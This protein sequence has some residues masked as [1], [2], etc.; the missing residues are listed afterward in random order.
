MGTGSRKAEIMIVGE[1]PGAREDETHA[2]FVGPAGQLLTSLLEEVGISRDQCY[3]TNAAKCR[4]PGNA[5]P[6]RGEAKVCANTYLSEEVARVAP[7]HI[8]TLGNTALQATTGRSGITK[9]R[10]KVF[11]YGESTLFP[12]FHPAAAL[13]S[14]RYLP[15]I[16]ADFAAFSRLLSGNGGSYGPKTRVKIINT[17]AQLNWLIGQL[18]R[19]PTTAFDLE[20][21]GLEEWK[22]DARIVTL[23]FSWEAGTAAVVPLYHPERHE[24]KGLGPDQVLK[25]LKGVL[26]GHPKLVAHNGKF[27]ARWLASAGIFVE[28]KFDT[29]LAAHLLDENNPKGLK[30]LA[31][32][33]LGADDYDLG[34]ELQ[35]AQSIPLKRLCIYNGKDCDYTFRLRELFKP[36]LIEEGR[37]ARLFTKLIMPASNALTRVER[38]GLWVDSDRLADR[39]AQAEEVLRKL[40]AYMDQS[41][42]GIN[43]N[44]P[45]QV[46]LW[47]FGDLG[48]PILEETGTGNPSTRE[49]VLFALESQSQYVKALLKYR[50][51][52][53]WLTTYLIP[54]GEHTDDR[55]RIHTSY[56]LHG[57]V[58]GRLSSRGPNL[59]QV[60]R[61]PFIRG[62]LGAPRGWVFV[63]ADY[64]QIELRIA[65]M[66]AHERTMLRV[67]N[68]GQDLHTTTAVSI[69]RK[70]PEDI[71]KDERVIWGKHPNFGLLFG[72]GPGTEGMKGG[73]R[74]YCWD[75][76][77]EISYE[78]AR[79]TY[80][81]F[82]E[83]YEGLRSWHDRQKR[84]A[85]R[86]GRVQNALGRIRHLPDMQS[87]DP[88]VRA[89]AERQAINS[90]VQS[91]ASDL[92]LVSLVRLA[93][94]LPARVAR[95]IGTT[96]D[97]LMFEVRDGY[98]DEVA[99]LIRD[100]MQD[101]DYVQKVF[102]AEITV[103]IIAE[104]ETGQHWG[105]T[106][107]WA[108][109]Q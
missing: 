109:A 4:P 2:A 78:D 36:R 43:Y 75:N 21:T 99:P 89:E 7:A 106:E 101:M 10:G 50:K 46:A 48:L 29:M 61:D 82:H 95:I 23:G 98:V 62:I 13:R 55:S 34:G 51:W 88:A 70:L 5:T 35:S 69:L 105:E 66:L 3:I 84:L 96:H 44:S 59:Q 18:S 103:P 17:A 93:S 22:D 30:P 28:V 9:Y 16:K 91:L 100:T 42:G 45:Q 15:T 32:L 86:Y 92:M 108:P 11:R 74:D 63:E 54:W 76:G 57:T 14:P 71:T 64:S 41:S 56:L 26:E 40:R 27:D 8:L 104:I 73:Y 19:A 31:Q 38:G 83:T 102:G 58:T 53:K 80:N 52:H 6:S 49:G 87:S 85:A 107:P 39:T 1:A 79:R 81:R 47:L 25:R 67:L 94:S 72:M 12:T 77:I 97:Q 65:A 68:T 60:P 24:L 37:L 90:P 20:T 33:H